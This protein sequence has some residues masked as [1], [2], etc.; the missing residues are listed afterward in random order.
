MLC[1]SSTFLVPE[2]TKY[3]VLFV[4][5]GHIKSLFM[6]KNI[7][8]PLQT[9]KP[10]AREKCAMHLVRKNCDKNIHTWT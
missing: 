6:R 8:N 3:W 5:C 9:K 1:E 2:M 10:P 7:I 4:I